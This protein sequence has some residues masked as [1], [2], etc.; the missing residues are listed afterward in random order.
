MAASVPDCCHISTAHTS[1]QARRLNLRCFVAA[2]SILSGSSEALWGLGKFV[3][4]FGRAL[5]SN[6]DT[7]AVCVQDTLI[8]HHAEF[9]KSCVLGSD[10]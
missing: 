5:S 3:W 2:L 8:F 1:N 7:E 6:K 9:S 4:L 10:T